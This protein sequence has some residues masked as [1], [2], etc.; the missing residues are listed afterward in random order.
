MDLLPCNCS[1]LRSATR[2]LTA[3]YDDA[4]RPSGLRTTQYS[5]LSRLSKV[6]PITLNELADMLAM[7]R[8]TLGRNLRPLEREGLVQLA[9][10]EVDK[11]ERVVSLTRA[12]KAALKRALPLWQEVHARFEEHFGAAESG[13]LRAL[14]QQVVSTGRELSERYAVSE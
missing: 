13:R 10:G 4:L 1:S 2:V 6:G 8:T 5:I 14:M 3:L 11:R 7:D 12:G 9:V